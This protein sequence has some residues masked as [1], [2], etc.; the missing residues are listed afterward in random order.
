MGT[1]VKGYVGT[2]VATVGKFVGY[3]GRPVIIRGVPVGYVGCLVIGT[4]VLRYVGTFV[5][6]RIGVAAY[7]GTAVPFGAFMKLFEVG[8][9]V[10]TAVA[11]VGVR[12]IGLVGLIVN[13]GFCGRDVGA[14]VGKVGPG[15]PSKGL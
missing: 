6:I 1:S 3:E 5:I 14:G 8:A 12:V 11:K 15:V 2:G 9:S 13:N 10:G 4:Y 7:V